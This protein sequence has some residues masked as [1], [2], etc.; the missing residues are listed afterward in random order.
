L[1]NVNPSASRNS[2]S[3]AVSGA[4]L[5][6]LGFFADNGVVGVES[7]DDEDSSKSSIMTD[8]LGLGVLLVRCRFLRG[9]ASWIIFSTPLH[10]LS[11]KKDLA[12]GTQSSSS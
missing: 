2:T 11:F 3:S 7:L 8:V 5:A 1:T 12:K 4:T 9:S 6:G 10:S